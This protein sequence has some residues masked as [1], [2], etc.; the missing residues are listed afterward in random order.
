MRKRLRKK[1]R[2]GEFRENMFGVRFSLR[3]GLAPDANDEFMWRFLEQA[4]EANGLL[5]GGGAQGSTWEFCVQLGGR[6]S[7][8]EAQ[9]AAVGAWL[10]HQPEVR[11]YL[12][13]DFF[14]GWHGPEEPPF[15]R[16]LNAVDAVAGD[17]VASGARRQ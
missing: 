10:A 8:S 1:R 12:L 14:D 5:C 16:D 2:F 9:R 6:G 4:I 15:P 3:D 13:G 11:S 7:P 17:G